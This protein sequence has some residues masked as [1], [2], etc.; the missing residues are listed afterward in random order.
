[1]EFLEAFLLVSWIILR[2]LLI[3][4][5][6]LLLILVCIAFL[7]T[8]ASMFK[9]GKKI[10]HKNNGYCPTKSPTG[11]VKPPPRIFGGQEKTTQGKEDVH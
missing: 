5:G 11:N 4:V 10:Q 1:M 3:F 9:G 6:I 8:Y 2:L 7:K